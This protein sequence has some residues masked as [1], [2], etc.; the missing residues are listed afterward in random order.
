MIQF[1]P[2]G[3]R[4]VPSEHRLVIVMGAN[5]S[6]FFQAVDK[7]LGSLSPASIQKVKSDFMKQIYKEQLDSRKFAQELNEMEVQ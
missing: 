2:E 5:P 3:F 4:E 6:A 7:T 1:G